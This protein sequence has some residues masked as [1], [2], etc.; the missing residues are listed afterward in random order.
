LKTQK[1]KSFPGEK[2]SKILVGTAS[3]SDPGFVEKWYPKKMRA[4]VSLACRE[5]AYIRTAILGP[6]GQR[7]AV[8]LSGLLKTP[9]P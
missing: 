7:R 6:N 4:A 5:L 2:N 9:W 3:W 8:I 1:M